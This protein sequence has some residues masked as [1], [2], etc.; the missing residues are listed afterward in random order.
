MSLF[1]DFVRAL[2][3]MGDPRFRAVLLRALLVVVLALAAVFWAVVFGLG[4][5]LPETVTLPW[6]GEVG[7]VGALLS[8]AALGLMLALSVVL[9]VPATAAAAGFFLDDV[10]AAVEARHYPGLPPALSPGLAR[11]AWDAARFLGLVLAANAAAL[12]VYVAVPPLAPVVFWLVNGFLL[13]R[14]YFQLV[15]LRRLGPA[16]AVRLR[17]RHAGRIW[18]AGVAMALP[19]SL[20]LVNLFVPIFG[21]AVFTHQFHRLAPDRAPA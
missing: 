2:G 8:W 16:E 20:P 13:G 14:E 17:R 11:Q 3:Q 1:A 18:L 9:M 21:V 4:R 19:L 12:V 6:L 10:A 15:S 7:F 5:V